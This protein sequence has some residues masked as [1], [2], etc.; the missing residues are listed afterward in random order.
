MQIVYYITY[1]RIITKDLTY[2][3]F[4]I[5]ENGGDRHDLPCVGHKGDGSRKHSR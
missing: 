2:F 5:I 4:F 1:L 3:P